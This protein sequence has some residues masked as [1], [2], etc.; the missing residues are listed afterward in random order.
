MK[1]IKYH[2]L[3]GIS[4]LDVAEILSIKTIDGVDRYYI[5]YEDCK[6]GMNIFVHILFS[7]TCSML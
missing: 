5:H 7:I 1:Y 4:I 3:F 2:L 6:Y